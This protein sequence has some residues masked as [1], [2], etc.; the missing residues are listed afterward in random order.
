MKREEIEKAA[1]YAIHQH[2]NCNGKYPC[3]ERDYCRFCAG[4]NTSYD[5]NECGADDFSEGFYWGT[6]WRINSVWH[7]AE[8]PDENKPCLVEYKSP[9]N[10]KTRYKVSVYCGYEWK[11]LTH[12]EHSCTIRWA[13]IED[14]L[15]NKED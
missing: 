7:K 12:Y 3:T 8:K 11:E 15:P 5:C 2:Y 14:L 4:S 6:N 10:G 13:Y 1:I 9:N